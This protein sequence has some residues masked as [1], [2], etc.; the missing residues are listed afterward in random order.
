MQEVMLREWNKGQKSKGENRKLPIKLS[1]GS[2][3]SVDQLTPGGSHEP[4]RD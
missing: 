4:G 1:S 3:V 2:P